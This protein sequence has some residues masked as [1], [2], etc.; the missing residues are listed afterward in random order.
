[1][2]LRC[3]FKKKRKNSYPNKSNKLALSIKDLHVSVTIIRVNPF[4]HGTFKDKD[5][6][7]GKHVV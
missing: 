6:D 3:S 7:V 5:V 2:M 4:L 1:M